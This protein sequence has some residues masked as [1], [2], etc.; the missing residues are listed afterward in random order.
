MAKDVSTQFLDDGAVPID[1]NAAEYAIRPLA[2]GRNGL[3]VAWRPDQ[4]RFGRPAL[5]PG[6]CP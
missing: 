5:G 2:V 1:N 3:L 4:Q 6:D